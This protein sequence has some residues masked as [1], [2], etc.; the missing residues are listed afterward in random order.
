MVK[1]IT[2]KSS[3]VQKFALVVVIFIFSVINIFI[4]ASVKTNDCPR[5]VDHCA[6]NM[7]S[8][9][10]DTRFTFPRNDHQL[11]IL[12]HHLNRTITCINK[13]IECDLTSNVKKDTFNGLLQLMEK[14]CSKSSKFR[15]EYLKHAECYHKLAPVYTKCYQLYYESERK[16]IE[17]NRNITTSQHLIL[18]CCN[19]KNHRKCTTDP[20]SRYCGSD[21]AN[22][23]EQI[24]IISEGQETL[25]HCPKHI[26]TSSTCLKQ[27]ESLGLLV[28]TTYT[29]NG[30]IEFLSD[31]DNSLYPDRISSSAFSPSTR[32]CNNH[33]NK[34]TLVNPFLPSILQSLALLVIILVYNHF[35]VFCTFPVNSCQHSPTLETPKFKQFSHLQ[36]TPSNGALK[37]WFERSSLVK[38][39]T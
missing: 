6:K 18:W 35:N 36:A 3:I 14:L 16:R 24:V 26:I 1:S 12:C 9:L 21:A 34:L 39:K 13:F 5:S 10:N 38:E 7:K 20:V 22:L 33:L 4:K 31:E 23:A 27:W 11:D 17:L 30:N 28:N 8:V 2:V 37:H 15:I 29:S 19:Y 32:K 25:D